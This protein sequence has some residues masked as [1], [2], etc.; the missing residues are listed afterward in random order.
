MNFKRTFILFLLLFVALGLFGLF[1][2]FPIWVFY[3]LIV[4][5][6]ATIIVG[7]F[8]M[9]LNFFLPSF[10]CS[11]MEQKKTI[12]LTFDDGPHPVYTPKVLALLKEYKATAT[13]FCIGKNVEKYPELL[14]QIVANGHTVGNHSY[15]HKHTIGFNSSKD[16]ILEIEKTDAI[17]KQLIQKKPIVFRPPYGVTTPHLAKAIDTKHHTVVGW[18]IR[19]FDGSP[20]R[21]KEAMLKHIK[22]KMKSGA[23]VLLHDTH[24]RIPYILEYTLMYLQSN[25]YKTVSVNDLINEN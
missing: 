15:S 3:L 13:F 8:S 19:P 23:I 17:I 7:S 16:W 18:S 24:E 2:S 20:L 1:I 6:I 22:R 25:G 9:S 14:K 12:S 11:K 10:N 5:F 4:L 21:T